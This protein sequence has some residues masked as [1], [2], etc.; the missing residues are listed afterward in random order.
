MTFE[1]YVHSRLA[2]LLRPAGV[3][4]GDRHLAEDVVQDV[5]TRVAQQ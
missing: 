3:L 2:S 5:L 4:S 1:E